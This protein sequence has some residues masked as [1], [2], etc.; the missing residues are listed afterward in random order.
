MRFFELI[1]FAFFAAV[2][3]YQ[4]YASS[5]PAGQSVPQIEFCANPP[6]DVLD[7]PAAPVLHL[8]SE[9]LQVAA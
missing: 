1:I 2:V 8:D 9:L 3:L 7:E 6:M 5:S 4:L